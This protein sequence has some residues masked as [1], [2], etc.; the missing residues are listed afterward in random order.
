MVMKDLQAAGTLEIEK[1]ERAY[2]PP[3]R[4]LLRL[5]DP[6]ELKKNATGRALGIGSEQIPDLIRM[7]TDD[8][9]HFAD[10][11]TPLIWAPLHAW[12]LLGELKAPEAVEPLISLFRRLDEDF[13]DWI[14]DEVPDVLVQIGASALSPLIAFLND[15]T[16]G[17]YSRNE[18]A[19]AIAKLAETY[20]DVRDSCIAALKTQLEQYAQQPGEF[21]GFLVWM[22][23][24]LHAAEALP[25]IERAFAAGRVDENSV[26]DWEDI[27]LEFGLITERSSP[28]KPNRLTEIG[29]A[30]RASAAKHKA[31]RSEPQ[32]ARQLDGQTR[33]LPLSNYKPGRNDPCTC[34]SGRKFKKCCGR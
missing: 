23:L 8:T 11:D 14:A 15:A 29:D 3:V 26:G 34:G 24:D 30:L 32:P 21:N 20:P 7:V 28:R 17:T 25:I 12:R 18:A 2:A 19:S 16:N 4:A 9:L 5:G 31:M 13:D 33:P 10:G 27:Q 22:L 6:R 1:A